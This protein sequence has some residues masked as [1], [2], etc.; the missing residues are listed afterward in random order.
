M[1]YSLYAFV[2][3]MVGIQ[4]AKWDPVLGCVFSFICGVL[5]LQIVKL[6]ERIITK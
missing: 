5:Y 3:L 4:I 1:R 2:V 6:I